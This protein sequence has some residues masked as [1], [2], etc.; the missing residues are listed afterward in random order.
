MARPP[1]RGLGGR[2]QPFQFQPGQLG[3]PARRL[4]VGERQG[5]AGRHRRA[6]GAGVPVAA[7]GRRPVVAAERDRAQQEMSHGQRAIEVEDPARLR[8]RLVVAVEPDQ[9]D[10]VQVMQLGRERVPRH[11]RGAGPR[12]RVEVEVR[13]R[14]DVHGARLGVVTPLTRPRR[15]LKIPALRARSSR[16]PRQR[17]WQPGP[18]PSSLS[19]VPA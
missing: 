8:R 15:C 17:H 6:E 13:Q 9:E 7:T 4:A 16:A 2:A 12:G 10:G 14:P 5:R 11:R 3:E 1:F 18:I 19:C